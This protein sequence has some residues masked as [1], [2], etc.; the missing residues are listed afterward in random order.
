ME[1]E[2][3]LVATL[4]AA[5]S[6]VTRSA[7]VAA[8]MSRGFVALSAWRTY[9]QGCG[10]GGVRSGALPLSKRKSRATMTPSAGGG[11][12]STRSTHIHEGNLHGNGKKNEN[13]TD[14]NGTERNKK[15]L[16]KSGNQNHS[17]AVESLL[18]R[19]GLSE[20]NERNGAASDSHVAH[21]SRQDA[22]TNVEDEDEEKDD[23]GEYIGASSLVCVPHG[24]TA[25]VCVL[26]P[27]GAL[28][29][30]RHAAPPRRNAS[31]DDTLTA[32]SGGSD[33][34]I[35]DDERKRKSKLKP[36]AS[37]DPLFWFEAFPSLYLRQAQREFRD[38]LRECVLAASDQQRSV[39]AMER[40]TQSDAAMTTAFTSP[41]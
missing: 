27:A 36:N 6:R 33:G 38:A 34:E 1:D 32:T 15:Q 29:C 25:H 3:A 21:D 20:Q 17:E 5:E 13:S 7:A 31:A 30:I 4:R 8:S 40:L 23:D 41:S 14:D 22:E 2:D 10:A 37:S 39:L 12:R 19:F 24:T 9:G 28:E 18:E 26:G 16:G 11:R 35:E